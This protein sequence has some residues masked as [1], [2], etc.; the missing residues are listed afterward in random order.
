MS[1]TT[2]FIIRHAEKPEL[3]GA[4]PGFT[5]DGTA[6]QRSLVIRG[7]QRAGTWAALFAA[8]TPSYPK[9]HVVYAADPDGGG[10]G[11]GDDGPSRRPFETV[12]P[13]A[14]RLGLQVRTAWALGQEA[15]LAREASATTGTILICWEHKR[16]VSALLPA[17]L[18]GQEP[19]GLPAKWHRE[20][21]DVVLRLDRIAPDAPWR[22]QQCWPCLLAGDAASPV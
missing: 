5:A 10:V 18:D 22:F 13:L 21:F 16:I 17:L 9:P 20:R 15:E 19:A 11:D 14:A 1:A 2:L 8:D 12:S 3:P 6:D 7:W 4:G